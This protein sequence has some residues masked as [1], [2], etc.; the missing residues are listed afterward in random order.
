MNAK[1][2]EVIVGVFHRYSR[3]DL[4]VAVLFLIEYIRANIVQRKEQC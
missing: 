3:D 4:V 2:L 1:G